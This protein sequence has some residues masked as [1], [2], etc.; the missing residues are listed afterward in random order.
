MHLEMGEQPVT[1]QSGNGHTGFLHVV[2]HLRKDAKVVR[3]S[4]ESFHTANCPDA[5]NEEKANA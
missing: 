5:Y 2:E 1:L 3:G 4:A